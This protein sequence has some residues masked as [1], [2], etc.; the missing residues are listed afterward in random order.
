MQFFLERLEEQAIELTN[1]NVS[2]ENFARTILNDKH[3][4]QVESPLQ[5]HKKA[6]H[7][8]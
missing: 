5:S 7:F 3:V 8:H 1:T 6:L 4:T 2:L